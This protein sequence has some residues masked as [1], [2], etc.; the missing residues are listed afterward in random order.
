MRLLAVHPDQPPDPAIVIRRDPA[1]PSVATGVVLGAIP[2]WGGAAGQAT[3]DALMTELTGWNDPDRFDIRIRAEAD[4]L[5]FAIGATAGNG[6]PVPGALSGALVLPDGRSL[7]LGL[8]P[9]GE[10]GRFAGQVIWP[11]DAAA[12]RGMLVLSE[13][14]GEQRIPLRLPQATG[15][16]AAAP[17]QAFD[18]G[19]D[20]ALLADLAL[21]SGGS[22][23][24]APGPL[25]AIGAAPNATP[26]ALWFL[27]VGLLAFALSFWIGGTR[28]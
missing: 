13:Q 6:R 1:R 11:A 22:F 26:F 18:F 23:P 16:A 4:R 17:E 8:A 5:A 12:L 21:L 28:P 19:I 20:T 14:D 3:L 24:A 2:A 27:A 10:P 25:S 7:P 15:G 9:E